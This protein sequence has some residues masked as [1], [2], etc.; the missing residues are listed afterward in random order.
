MPT[1]DVAM[2]ARLETASA[3]WHALAWLVVGNTIGVMLAVLLL[4]PSLNSW[5]GEWTYGR[6]MMVHM[7]TALFGWA[8][9]PM[10]A[11][12]FRVYGVGN[13]R[14]GSWSRAVV[15]LWSA[16]LFVGCASWLSGQSSGKLFLD[17]SG[18]ARVFFITV[19]VVLW[20][21]LAVAFAGQVRRQSVSAAVL[22]VKALGLL[23]L[24]A[25][26]LALYLASSPAG[27]PHVNPDTGGPTGQSQLESSLGVV[28]L[29]LVV[30]FGIAPRRECRRNVVSF[31]WSALAAEAMLCAVL[32]RADVSHHV[33]AQWL[34][35][36]SL[37]VWI[38]LVPTYYAA[39]TWNAATRLWRRAFQWWW[40]ALVVTGWV[41]FLPGVLDRAKFTD[42]LVGHSLMAVAGFLS[43]FL[44]FVLTQLLGESDAWVLAR[45]GS[46]VA[47]NS[48][49]AA[50]VVLMFVA[51]WL[52][53]ENPAFTAMPGPARE[54]IYI[55]RLLTGLVMLAA[56][57]DWWIAA[58]DLPTC[59]KRATGAQTEL[60]A[61]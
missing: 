29:L 21:F 40:G 59:A 16:G 61:A 10:L 48:A 32:G 31:A 52:E 39:F 26:P 58:F 53:S 30:P 46:F 47:W 19:L 49:V 11:F 1:D 20:L 24:L 3:S 57:L 2:H 18:F 43:A 9:L 56:S 8:S 55:L 38:P 27:Y 44:I 7:N 17:W 6:W 34:S 37:L 22:V 14:T 5:L 23:A 36:A 60:E 28:V 33:I 12:L 13:S 50:Y 51:G 41:L 45:T 4:M 42:T 35:L 15:W 54:L 25:V